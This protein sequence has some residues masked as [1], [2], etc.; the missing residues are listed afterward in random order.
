VVTVTNAGIIM[1][2]TGPRLVQIKADIS[3]AIKKVIRKAKT[4]AAG[5]KPEATKP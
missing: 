4:D 3:K 2:H 1:A 5:N